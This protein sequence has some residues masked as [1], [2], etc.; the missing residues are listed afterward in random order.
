MEAK[1]IIEE[2]VKLQVEVAK[3]KEG[4]KLGIKS[5]G[6]LDYMLLLKKTRVISFKRS[7]KEAVENFK[8]FITK[9]FP[10]NKELNDRINKLIVEVD[11]SEIKDLIAF[12]NPAKMNSLEKELSNHRI[13]TELVLV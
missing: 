12:A 13:A 10:E 9:H 8:I 2:I 4:K 1:K 3:S 7:Y 11:N 5:F 6:D